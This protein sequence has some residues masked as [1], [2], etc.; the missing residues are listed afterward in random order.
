MWQVVASLAG[1]AG[2]SGNPPFSNFIFT[3]AGFRP[4]LAT[5]AIAA[6]DPPLAGSAVAAR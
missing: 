4:G 3:V 1:F 2:F 5:S 6:A